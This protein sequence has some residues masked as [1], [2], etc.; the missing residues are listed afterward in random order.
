MLFAEQRKPLHETASNYLQVKTSFEEDSELE[1]KRM[2]RHIL[3]FE[4]IAREKDLST[5][6]KKKVNI[7]RVQTLIRSGAKVIKRGELTK[8][9]DK[10]S[11]NIEKRYVILT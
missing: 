6:A 10:A 5:R 11:K 4:D 8:E 3:A 7:K 9:G 1:C 2:V